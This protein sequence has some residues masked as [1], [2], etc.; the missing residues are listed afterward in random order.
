[1]IKPRIV[2]E[3]KDNKVVE[4]PVQMKKWAGGFALSQIQK[5]IEHLHECYRQLEGRENKRVL[6]VS[7][8]SSNPLGVQLSAFNLKKYVPSLN[9]K[10]PVECIFQAGKVFENG[11]PYLDLLNVKPYEAKM[12][13][14]LKN[15]GK[16]I[17]FEFESKRYPTYPLTEFYDSIYAEAL[18]ENKEL[19]K[20]VLEYDAFTDFMFNQEKSINCQARTCAKFKATN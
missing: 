18:K 3:V 15:S 17:A 13:N 2:F 9:K 14:R 7:T 20:Q 10:I 11:G 12:D 6:E 19:A 16:L 4:T 5:N 1:M 8:K